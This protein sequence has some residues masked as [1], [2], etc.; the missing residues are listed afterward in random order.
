MHHE[1]TNASTSQENGVVE[2]LNRTILEMMRTMIHESD[3]PR[4]LWPF[5]VQYTQAIVNRLLIRALSE[6]KTLY[7]AFHLKKLSVK[8]L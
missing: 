1:V 3:L 4:N 2:H 8:H 6:N 5:T 7:E